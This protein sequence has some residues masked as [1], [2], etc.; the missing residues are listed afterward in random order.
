MSSPTTASLIDELRRR[1]RDTLPSVHSLTIGVQTAGTVTSA[2]LEVTHGHLIFTGSGGGLRS[3]D[4]ELTNPMNSTIG[5][6][7]DSLQRMTGMVSVIDRLADPAHLSLD[8]ESFGPRDISI[9]GT[10]LRHRTFSDQELIK[11]LESALRRHNPSLTIYNLPP[12]EFELTLTLAQAM[13]A[14]EKASDTVKRK[15]TSE[16]VADLLSI[17]NQYE[18]VYS[19]DNK[20]LARV[21]QS[22]KEGNAN[23][24][25]QGDVM[26]GGTY[27][28][29]LRTGLMTPMSSALPIAPPNLYSPVDGDDEDD[30]VRVHWDR[31]P[32]LGLSGYEMWMDTNP[33]VVRL[34]SASRG[35]LF[36]QDREEE[37][38]I[39]SSTFLGS[40]RGELGIF[41]G[42][43][44]SIRIVGRGIITSAI[45]GNLE[46][47]TEYHFRLFAMS[48]NGEVS[49]SEVV[50]HRTRARRAKLAVSSPVLPLSAAAAVVVTVAL[51]ADWAPFTAAHT[52]TV[53]GKAVT[54]TIV[55]PR[56]VTFV[57][58]TFVQKGYKD[59][60]VTSPDG[61]LKSVLR[62]TFKVV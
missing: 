37:T 34:P 58:P 54:V 36:I 15:N 44:H 33:N 57:V 7:H 26:L 18:E 19:R 52:L 40:I 60:V 45:V 49:A 55:A 2:L 23:S 17:A 21:I 22:P 43:G 62:D 30:N 4:L 24:T 31:S 5:A 38:R 25:R 61:G 35:L 16:S 9:Q 51:H 29:N 41:A 42:G 10:Q 59:V 27:R 53:G 56:Q 20:R 14:R 1:I 3:F 8:L 12:A 48:V 6:L 32:E 39:T 11:I 46:P 50:E 13:V 28:K 47:S